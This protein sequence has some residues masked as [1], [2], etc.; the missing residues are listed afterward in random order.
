MLASK[1]R[2]VGADFEDWYSRDLLPEAQRG[3]PLRLLRQLEHY[4]LHHAV[5]LSTTS[6]V[7]A[8]AM[9]H[10]YG[11]QLPEVVYNVFQWSERNA[12]DNVALDR[13]DLT[14]PSLHWVSKVIGQGRGLE[15]LFEALESVVT[16]VEV[17]L[18]GAHSEQAA[19]EL[20][21]QFPAGQGHRLFLHDPV[22]SSQLLSRISE[23][24]IGLAL[25]ISQMPSRDLTVTYKLFHYLVGG[26]AVVAT[27]TSGQAE[28]AASIP[29]AVVLA[30]QEDAHDLANKITGL[31]SNK[32][33]LLA[34]KAA[35][36]S[37]AESRFCWE[38]QAPRVV[39]SIERALV[40]SVNPLR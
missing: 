7:L 22:P 21:D 6:H 28:I 18:R 3:R 20:Q 40:R 37:A 8:T 33:R 2:R 27:N 1:G 25:E 19:A 15:L 10:A 13:V 34:A 29:D 4:L 5:H 30:N 16:P 31:V 23:H 9:Q 36:L 35:A 26:L 11:G 32:Q 12:I 39:K 14:K 17:H 38:Q 24:D